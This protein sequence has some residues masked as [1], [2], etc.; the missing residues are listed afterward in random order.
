MSIP[1]CTGQVG[2]LSHNAL[3]QGGV[4][5]SMHWAEGV[6]GQGSVCPGDGVC[7]P[8][9][10][11]AD[12]TLPCRNYIADGNN[13]E[14]EFCNIYSGLV[15]LEFQLHTTQHFGFFT[16]VNLQDLIDI[17]CHFSKNHGNLNFIDNGLFQVTNIC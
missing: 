7:I 10:T 1:A 3:G 5:S 16:K 13:L 6:S 14:V 8:A 2:C 9:Y 12:K 4:Y 11:G 15:F 17:K